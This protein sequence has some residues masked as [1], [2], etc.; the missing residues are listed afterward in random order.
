MTAALIGSALVFTACSNDDS[1]SNPSGIVLLAKRGD[2]DYFRQI[3]K[4]FRDACKENGLKAYYYCT[5]A[6]KAYEDQVAAMEEV[7][8]L[9]KS[10]KGII[11]TPC[12]GD[13]GESVEDVVAAFAKEQGIPVVILDS[14]V[15]HSSPLASCPYFGSDN[16]ESGLDLALEVDEDKI[17]AFAM[18]TSPGMERAEAFKTL[19]TDTEIYSVDEDPS[20]EVEAV[21]DDF[22][23]FVFFNGNLLVDIFSILKENEKTIYS[24]DV[25][26]LFLDELIAGSPYLKGIMA[27]NTFSMTKKAVEAVINNT[28]K[29]EKVPTFFITKDNLDDPN[30][31]PFLEFYGK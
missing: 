20:S 11:Y 8:K 29:G 27:Q 4:A 10:V 2:V 16:I 6:D 17:A 3:E 18:K 14:E 31:Q 21:I 26:E 28:K 5:K 9:G 12:Y 25:C 13:N 24:F 15:K 1:P 22:D 30:V 19:K 23:N 7:I